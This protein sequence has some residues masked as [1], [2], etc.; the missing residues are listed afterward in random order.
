MKNLAPNHRGNDVIL[1]E[2][3]E[4]QFSARFCYGPMDLVTLS[5][6]NVSAFVCPVGSDW[7]LIATE[8]TDSHGRVTFTVSLSLS[9]Y[10]FFFFFFFCNHE[11]TNFLISTVT[12]EKQTASRNSR[13]KN[14]RSWR[15]LIS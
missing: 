12:A 4:Q 1:V 10:F 9:F 3:S 8:L 13:D 2:G 15:S 7:Q 11:I 6:E 14:D 5:R